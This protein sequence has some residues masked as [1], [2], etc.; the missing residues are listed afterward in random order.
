M[1]DYPQEN[2]QPNDIHTHI[3]IWYDEFCYRYT[4]NNSN[5][6]HIHT[7]SSDFYTYFIVSNIHATFIIIRDCKFKLHVSM[8][9]KI[10][11]WTCSIDDRNWTIFFSSIIV[12]FCVLQTNVYNTKY[13]GLLYVYSLFLLFFTPI[14]NGLLLF[15]FLAFC[16]AH[17]F[18]HE[19]IGFPNIS[20]YRLKLIILFLK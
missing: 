16:L 17:L 5:S 20:I 7:T 18:V 11:K 12:L 10:I 15:F 4:A 1:Y 3:L 9:R 13:A 6:T 14:S 19:K 8:I 2:S